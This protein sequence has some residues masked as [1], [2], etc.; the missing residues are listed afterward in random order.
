MS[1]RALEVRRSFDATE[2]SII[3][4][5]CSR[6]L[7]RMHSLKV[8]HRDLKPANIFLD[9]NNFPKI[10][11]FGFAKMMLGGN[12]WTVGSPKYMAPEVLRAKRSSEARD[13]WSFPAD[14]YAFAIIAWELLA[15]G[16]W[17][18][19]TL[20][21]FDLLEQRIVR[22]LRPPR[23]HS[24]STLHWELLTKMWDGDPD[25]RPTFDAVCRMLELP[26]YW[27][28]GV[29]QDR[30]LRYVRY[31]EAE[32]GREREAGMEWQ[33]YLTQ[34]ASAKALV[35]KLM[36]EESFEGMVVRLMGIMCGTG[37]GLNEEVREVVANC[38]DTQEFLVPA[39]INSKAR[40]PLNDIMEDSS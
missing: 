23:R 14:V 2:R 19:P 8:L 36:A 1:H 6:A 29:D 37:T 40:K 5:G 39:I 27:I 32:E 18:L 4:Y 28:D 26:R 35:A 10:G 20:S 3:L 22:G 33:E 17:E 25:K 34:S 21:S 16:D 31:V 13:I 12:T 38:L 24:I 30:F 7:A 15:G 11:D 9:G